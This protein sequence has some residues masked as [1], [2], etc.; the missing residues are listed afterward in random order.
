MQ[1]SISREPKILLEL[2]CVFLHVDSMNYINL[3]I[4]YAIPSTDARRKQ[5]YSCLVVIPSILTL[6]ADFALAGNHKDR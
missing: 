6:S 2:R 4:G 3:P 1:A 5:G